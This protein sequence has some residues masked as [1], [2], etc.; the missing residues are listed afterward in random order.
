MGFSNEEQKHGCMKSV[1]DIVNPNTKDKTYG[2]HGI[3]DYQL[4]GRKL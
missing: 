2:K 3:Q 1:V 4:T